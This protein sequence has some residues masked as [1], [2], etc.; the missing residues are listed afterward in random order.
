MVEAAKRGQLSTVRQLLD[1]GASILEDQDEVKYVC[2]CVCGCV[3]VCVGV[4]VCECV[5]GCVW[6]G[7]HVRGVCVCILT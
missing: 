4:W 6:V 7:A 1:G 2:L 3:G 5:C